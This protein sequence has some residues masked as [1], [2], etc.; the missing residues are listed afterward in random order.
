MNHLLNITSSII[1]KKLSWEN[2]RQK[3]DLFCAAKVWHHFP[4]QRQVL[5]DEYVTSKRRV[6]VHMLLLALPATASA[7][8]TFQVFT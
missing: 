8:F 6:V 7:I 2:E 4:E 5:V 1:L 3:C